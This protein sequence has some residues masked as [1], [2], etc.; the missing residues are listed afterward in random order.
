ME[1]DRP[2][3]LAAAGIATTQASP[4]TRPVRS[5]IDGAVVAH[6]DVADAADADAAAARAVAAFARLRALPMPARGQIVRELGDAFRQQ[7]TVLGKVLTLEVGK[8]RSEA[9]GEIQEIVD[10]CDF[11]CGLSRSIGGA[12]W[13]SERPD[14]RLNERWHPLGPVLCITA[15]NF[16]AAVWGWNAALALV[17]GDPIVWKPSLKAALTAT[18]VA[19]V[20]AGVLARHGLSDA[21]QLLIVDDTVA[22]AAVGDR[23]YPLVSATGSTRMGRAVQQ[24]VAA[25]LGRSLLEL[26]G[27]NAVVVMDDA[28]VDLALRAVVFGAFGTAGQRCTSTRRVLVHRRIAH[29][30]ATRLAA[31][32]ERLVVGDPFD[33]ATLV[34]PLIDDD[35][36]A[37]FVGAIHTAKKQGGEVLCGGAI[38]GNYVR[39]AVVRSRRDMPLC[40]Q[41]T[42]GPLV[43]VIEID[44][45]DDAIAV[46]NDSDHG[47][48][49][50]IFTRDLRVA[51]RFVDGADCGLCN[52]N[53][54]TSGAEIGG[55]FGGEKDSGGGRESGGDSWKQYMRRQTSAVN[56]GDGLPLAQGVR[57]DVDEEGAGQ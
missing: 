33:P 43:H 9:E 46:N 3:I 28:D 36:V 29:R 32:A 30:F 5:P 50:A 38:S 52:V 45:V 37:A 49:A 4:R 27:N 18:A 34:G 8:I 54:G 7:K 20:A 39:P 42:F 11:A 17:C 24:T 53:T 6:V 16:P 1:H 51:E 31:V 19:H 35:A 41:E 56:F 23:R 10:V 55:A 21:A 15:F 13:A 22:A 2:S 44:D 48:S 57:F 26:G 25:R 40:R 47:L 12:T 14:H